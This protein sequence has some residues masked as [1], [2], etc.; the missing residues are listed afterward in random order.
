MATN[1]TPEQPE[2][3]H[4]QAPEPQIPVPQSSSGQSSGGLFG[5]PTKWLL[6]AG[7]GGSS[8]L[9][10]IVVVVLLF[11]TGAIGGSNPQPKSV[12]DLIPDEA[13][14]V[15][16]MDLQRILE[17]DL[18]AEAFL[19]SEDDFEWL[20]KLGIDPDELTEMTMAGSDVGELVVLKGNFDFDYIRDEMEDADSEENAYRGYEVWEDVDGGAGAF[21]DGYIIVSDAVRPVENVLKNLY[22]GSGSLEQADEDNEMKQILEKVGS[23]FVVTASTSDACRAER[24]EGYGWALTEVDESAEEGK[25]EIALLFRNERAAERAADDYDQ[26]ADFLEQ[27]GFDI[28]DTKEDGN[29]VV[30]VAIQDLAEEESRAPAERQQPEVQAPAALAA[31]TKAARVVSL[32]RND[33][34]DD[35]ENLDQQIP[36][37]AKGEHVEFYPPDGEYRKHCECIHD[38]MN[39]LYSPWVIPFVSDT[40]SQAL[41]IAYDTSAYQAAWVD[42]SGTGSGAP[43]VLYSDYLDD[44]LEADDACYASR[45]AS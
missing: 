45:G 28:E 38:H 14:A 3:I 5:I 9:A 4:P 29:F 7:G 23:G 34:I 35:C 6:I 16:R 37:L 11:V 10:I 2:E 36:N 30:G 13:H 31:P 25:V 19:D 44:L 26:V 21:L 33:W 42:M 39:G 8:A 18:L 12:L 22:N 40:Y 17:N 1:G 43:A 32:S 24:C 15:V 20:D 41:S 27:E